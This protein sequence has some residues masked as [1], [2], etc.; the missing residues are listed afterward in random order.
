MS[1]ARRS[2]AC[3][4]ISNDHH[5]YI[6]VIGGE[7]VGGRTTAVELLNTHSLRWS[8]LTS[9]PKP[10]PFPSAV[11][12]GDLV[13]VIEGDCLYS[14]LLSALPDSTRP[15]KS[16]QPP[17]WTPLPHLPLYNSTPAILAGQL[18]C[19]GCQPGVGRGLRRDDS[20]QQ[21]VDGQWVKIGSLSSAVHH[22]LVVTPS[23][24]SM[25][26]VGGLT[27]FYSNSD[28]VEMYEV[29]E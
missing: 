24:D 13:Y 15:D 11:V 3:V 18:V 19:V 9:L 21:R 22:C 14:Y 17:I 26:V 8:T 23:P 6:M 29:I 2:A 10:L 12:C 27:E 5:M 4:G 28:N 25:L 7:G 1:I 16:L 20:I